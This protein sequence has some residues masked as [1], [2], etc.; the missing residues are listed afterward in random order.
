ML[1]Y[2]GVSF[3]DLLRVSLPLSQAQVF[4][5]VLLVT[6]IV[7]YEIAQ[8]PLELAESELI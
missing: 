4:R 8:G 3:L 5:L 1:P 7:L 6:I 2:V